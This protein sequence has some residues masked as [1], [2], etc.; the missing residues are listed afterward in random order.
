MSQRT[1]ITLTRVCIVTIGLF[2]LTWGLWY[3]ISTNLWDYMA[4]TGTV[5]FAGALPAIVCGLY[6]KRA[7]SVGAYGALLGGLCGLLAMGPSLNMLNESLFADS[8]FTLRGAHITILTFVVSFSVF[9]VGSLL[10][11]DRPRT[12]TSSPDVEG[13]ST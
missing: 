2:L 1:R 8:E 4:I 9:V 10:F 7:S 11:P 13:K 3:E 12:E 6:W 5:Y